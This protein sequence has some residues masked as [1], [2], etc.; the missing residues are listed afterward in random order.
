MINLI[1]THFHLDY[2]K[3]HAKIYYDINKLKQYTL[4][5]TN[6]PEV[7]ESCIDLYK[8]T[9][10]VRFAL[11]YN[12]QC[13]KE[14]PFNKK[15]F[16]RCINKTKYIGEVGLDFSKQYIQYKEKQVDI[17]DYICKVA[18]RENKIL[19]IHSRKA[20]KEVLKILKSNGVKYAILHWYTGPLELIDDFIKEGYY[21]SINP[22]M[23]NSI[24]GI[25]IINKIPKERILVE[26]DGPFG[27]IAGKIMEPKDIKSGYLILDNK[28]DG[29]DMVDAI[30]NNFRRILE[31]Q[32][33]KSQNK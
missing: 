31:N 2:Y 9:K 13:I 5:V 24:K 20:E 27:K 1:D 29:E 33:H 4:C 32:Q 8:E 26:S 15:A 10:Y 12:P 6:S 22:T 30:Y 3:N 19:S 7:F 11:G 23:I 21:F 25:K 14:F 18:A 28:F 17:F 16:L